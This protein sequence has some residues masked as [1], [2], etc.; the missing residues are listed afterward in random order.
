MCTAAIGSWDGTAFRE[1][2]GLTYSTTNAFNWFEGQAE[3]AGDLSLDCCVNLSDWALLMQ[4]WL[5]CTDPDNPIL[6]N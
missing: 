6:C 4:G 2:N 1:L 3:N 5:S